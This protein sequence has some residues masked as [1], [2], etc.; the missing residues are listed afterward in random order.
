M[1]LGIVAPFAVRCGICTYSTYLGNA[2][3][4]LK[5]SVTG[6]SEFPFPDENVI[7]K[8]FQPSFPFFNC[9]K[10][11]E[12]YN[13]LIKESKK[14]DL[15]HIQHQYGLFNN[16]N[17]WVTLLKSI[18]SK[19]ILTVHDMVPPN[20]QL[21][22]Y[23]NETFHL[24]DKLIVHTPTCYEM[25]LRWNCPKEKIVQIPHGTKL[26]DVPNKDVARETLGLPKDAKII[27]SWGFIWES[28]GILELIE[29]LKEIK[30]TYPEAIFIHAGGVHPILQKS[31]YLGKILKTAVQF[32]LTPKDLIITGWLPE[33]SVPTY[34]GVADVIVLNY[35]RGSA[36]ASG[37]GHRAMSGHRPIVK[38]DD[39]CLEDIPGFTVPRFS[40]TE[41]YQG[42]LKVLEDK[43]LQEE[44][45]SQ[46]D[47]SAKE[48]SWQNVALMHKKLYD[49]LT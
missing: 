30:K 4:N 41:L 39:N 25:L 18:K 9:W 32:G 10:R 27:L 44:L 5:I 6:L 24:A 13:D 43:K 42:I 21:L 35:A 29:I 8:D 1:Q 49:E 36:S 19:K 33:E 22:T 34:F 12:F 20:E 45:I 40:S 31:Q 48:T 23:F 28:K 14:Y 26:I 2:L 37:A 3:Q 15:I 17:A 7:T 11:T 46:A 16:T 38:S 47:K